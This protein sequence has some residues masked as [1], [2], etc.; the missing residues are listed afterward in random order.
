M[1]MATIVE[2]VDAGLWDTTY[3][4]TPGDT[5]EGSQMLGDVDF[6]SITLEAGQ[7]YFVELSLINGSTSPY[8]L[9][10]QM[11]W[12][13]EEGNDF[14][15]E[16]RGSLNTSGMLFIAPD[17]GT[18]YLAP[19]IFIFSGQTMEYSISF[20]EVENYRVWELQEIAD[21]LTTGFWQDMNEPVAKW[22]IPAPGGLRRITYDASGLGQEGE[23]LAGLAFEAWGSISDIWFD[24]V[25]GGAD[26]TFIPS[27]GSTYASVSAANGV[28]QS[29]LIYVESQYLTVGVDDRLGDQNLAVFIHEIGHT[30]GL[31]HAG[32]YDGSADYNYDSIFAND[33]YQTTV[34]SYFYARE[35]IFAEAVYN[36]PLSPMPA[37]V[38]AMWDLYGLVQVNET[39]TVYGLSAVP[40]EG[41]DAPEATVGAWMEALANG[42]D[43][44]A[45]NFGL[46]SITDTGGT[47]WI[48]VSGATD[49]FSS[50]IDLRDSA[51]STLLGV[52]G[53]L[54]LTPGT[55]IEN[56]AGNLADDWLMGNDVANLL[57][58]NAG[59]DTLEGGLGDDTLEGGAGMDMLIAGLDRDLAMGEADDD[60]IYLQS[61]ETYDYGQAA[62]NVGS[63]EQVGTGALAALAGKNKF[64]T[65]VDGGGAVDRVVLTDGN[66][67]LFLHDAISGFYADAVLTED[68]AGRDSTSRLS[69]IEVIEAGAGND[70]IDLTSP[71]YEL[72][73]QAVGR[74]TLDAGAGRDTVWGSAADEDI[75]GGD[76][77]DRLFGGAGVDVLTGGAGADV[78]EFT[79]TS[80]QS[81]ITDFSS[82]D[83][84]RIW[85]HDAGGAA[86]DAGTLTHLGEVLSIDYVDADS[87][88]T[89]VLSLTV[90]G[91][92]A[93]F[94]FSELS[95]AVFV[96]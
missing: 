43:T 27:I 86:F 4:L 70:V 96:V 73:S 34:M 35:Q 44:V 58:G 90:T 67:A 56:A 49:N 2:T 26:I 88:Q 51:V 93:G 69:G 36:E 76:G 14:F 62:R 91:L 48:D 82:S 52:L 80:T 30:L 79:R 8:S 55:V 41:T 92:G 18:Y 25:D 81:T 5:F 64:E 50:K 29:A 15:V 46:F 83:G 28:I 61:N 6:V 32:P 54:A 38:L 7:A 71:D 33:T 63:A 24:P 1:C 21:Y 19:N 13:D 10:P 31:G 9:N 66:D 94:D 77:N 89:F 68:Y 84:D 37:D 72:A 16:P 23:R 59:A 74:I 78:F 39:D 75:L 17:D 40:I 11:I 22:D 20:Q 47:D 12:L 3:F 53:N 87:G 85:F 42:Q 60:V 65:V 95:D 45:N 57:Q